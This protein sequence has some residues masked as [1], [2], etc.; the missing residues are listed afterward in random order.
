MNR[1]AD[2]CTTGVGCTDDVKRVAESLLSACREMYDIGKTEK[3]I[4]ADP[5]VRLLAYQMAIL[6]QVYFIRTA[7]SKSNGCESQLKLTRAHVEQNSVPETGRHKTALAIT[8]DGGSVASIT[9]AILAG[10]DEVRDERFS[11][12]LDPWSVRHDAAL[13]LM[14]CKLSELVNAD[15]L[16]LDIK[17]FNA[18][19]AICADAWQ[20]DLNMTKGPRP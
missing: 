16:N 7:P 18:N 15:E 12:R 9:E 17:A 3:D 8:E 4:C 10:Y 20:E 19:L 2:A 5:A 13:H 11:N 14:A 6:F 1:H